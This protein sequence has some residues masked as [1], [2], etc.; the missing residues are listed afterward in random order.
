MDYQIRATHEKRKRGHSGPS[1]TSQDDT[2]DIEKNELAVSPVRSRLGPGQVAQHEVAG[3]PYDGDLLGPNFPHK[4]VKTSEDGP[5]SLLDDWIA[6]PDTTRRSRTI[7]IRNGFKRQHVAVLTAI[8][9]RCM[10]E[11]DYTRAG[12]AWGM[13][14]RMEFDG[15]SI[16]LRTQ[17]IWGLGAEI[18]MFREGQLD[19]G[20][21]Q[22]SNDYHESQVGETVLSSDS[23]GERRAVSLFDRRGFLKAKDYYERLI[24]QYP[25]RKSAPNAVSSLHF[26]PAMF[27][28]WIFSVQEQGKAMSNSAKK[29]NSNGITKD[30]DAKSRSSVLENASEQATEINARLDELLVSPPYSDDARLWRLRGLVALWEADLIQSLD[31]STQTAAILSADNTPARISLQA[32]QE[33]RIAANLK[34]RHAFENVSRLDKSLLQGIR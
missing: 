8:L 11:G 5:P 1:S 24:L 23:P 10:L 34:A 14:L 2:A 31:I 9:H 33:Q 4:A 12:R 22:E 15:H 6:A 26:Y 13:L 7:S 18:L 28:F 19:N 16:D 30:Q 32:L 17:G 29:V 21:V 20:Q 27:T 25:Y 3:Q